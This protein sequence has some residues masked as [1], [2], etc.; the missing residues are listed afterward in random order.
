MNLGE[1]IK[2]KAGQA[3]AWGKNDCCTFCA[4]WLVLNG[5]PDPMLDIRGEYS[6][7]ADAEAIIFEHGDLLTLW[8]RILG[9][10]DDTLTDGAVA[11]I[12]FG[13]EQLG[14]IVS[15]D[16]LVLLRDRGISAVSLEKLNI[17]GAW[18]E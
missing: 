18:G 9:D 13:D 8:T 2:S 10:P 4:D 7:E 15:G 1:Y 16:R 5:K 17:L 12:E 14:G 6:N 3:F 11:I